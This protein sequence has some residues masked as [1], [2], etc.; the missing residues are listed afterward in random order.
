[1]IEHNFGQWAGEDE[2]RRKEIIEVSIIIYSR[3]AYDAYVKDA[4]IEVYTK[5]YLCS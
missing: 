2:E 4:A 3:M 5:P 1:M